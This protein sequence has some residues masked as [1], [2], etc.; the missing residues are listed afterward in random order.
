MAGCKV[1]CTAHCKHNSG[2]G[3]YNLCE[4]EHFKNM[5]M[6]GGID[7]R[8]VESCALKEEPESVGDSNE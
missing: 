7:R 3:Y 2:D 8:Y 4:H 6:Y 1:L 5:S